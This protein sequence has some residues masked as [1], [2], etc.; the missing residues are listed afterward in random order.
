MVTGPVAVIKSGVLGP[1]QRFLTG[2]DWRG[3]N[4]SLLTGRG[5]CCSA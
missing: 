3:F 4:A 1:F 5:R 2:I